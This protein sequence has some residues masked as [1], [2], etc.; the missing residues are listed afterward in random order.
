MKIFNTLSNLGKPEKSLSK[1]AAIGSFW[2][3][4][5]RAIQQVLSLTRLVVLARVLSPND[6]GLMGIAL[7]VMAT[8]E[9]F[10]QTG[11][12]QA[13]IQK[14]DDIKFYLDS[15]WT[16]STFRGLIIFVIL[17]LVAPYAATFFETPEA[18][19]IIK[20]IGVSIVFQAFSNIG[21]I[22]FQ[23]E[24]QF[25]K[26]FIYKLSG[27]MTDF[28]VSITAVFIL[29]NVWAIVYGM[30]AANAAMLITSY[31]V[32]PYRPRFNFN[33]TKTMELFNYGK[34][35]LGSSILVFLVTQGDDIVVG[36]LLGATYLGLYQ[37]AYRISNLPATEIVHVISEITFPLYSKIQDNTSKLKEAYEMILQFTAYISFPI[38][39]FIFIL[40]PELTLLFFGE[41]WMPMVPAIQVL[42]ISGLVRS[43]ASTS[44]CLFYAIGNVK[45]D[46]KLQVIRLLVLGTLIYPFTVRWGLVGASFSVL[47]S[48]LVSALG[49]SFE[50][51]KITQIPIKDYIA[52]FTTPFISTTSVV[53]S[54]YILKYLIYCKTI[55]D[56]LLILFLGFLIQIIFT[57]IF[58][59]LF[60][61]KITRNVKYYVAL[62]KGG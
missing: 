39:G 21:V 10:S 37:L 3:F 51:L 58:D 31:I 52:I 11:F 61:K 9:T 4:F 62:F 17:Y 44:G 40:A 30:L 12:Q 57:Y 53:I 45:I 15:A 36:K 55:L 29:G 26:Q 1:S 18:T 28:V 2:V 43:L 41:R 54:I 23:K 25:N 5:L 59:T 34:W 24:L 35:V 56:L 14:K 46:T 22:Y 60:G 6:F 49:F 19:P 42:S 33:I 7:L 48:I 32:H 20:V 16:L 13:L 8:L 50:S 47:F 27:T 38:T